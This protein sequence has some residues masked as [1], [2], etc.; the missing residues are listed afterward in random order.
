MLVPIPY[1]QTSTIPPLEWYLSQILPWC[2]H[3]SVR[4]K[5]S[6]SLAMV[7]SQDSVVSGMTPLHAGWL[8]NCGLITGWVR[9]CV[10][11]P[12]HQDQGMGVIQPPI[13]WVLEV[14]DLEMNLAMDYWPPS[15]AKVKTAHSC[16]SILP[17]TFMV[18][19]LMHRDNINFTLLIFIWV[20]MYSI[21]LV[22]V[23]EVEVP[24]V[25][26]SICSCMHSTDWVQEMMD[27]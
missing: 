23:L 12:Q 16:T 15:S 6:S 8:R 26:C 3:A 24:R 17:Y 18:W 7:R 1:V 5:P 19:Y 14:K 11:S 25:R 21:Y 22:L 9:R 2:S 4:R 10:S 27:A 13:Q 20:T